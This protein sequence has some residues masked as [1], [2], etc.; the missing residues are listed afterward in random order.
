MSMGSPEEKN[1]VEDEEGEEGGRGPWRGSDCSL[2]TRREEDGGD[3]KAEAEVCC[4]RTNTDPFSDF[5]FR[6]IIGNIPRFRSS[7]PSGFW[8]FRN[9]NRRE[10]T[11]NNHSCVH[12]LSAR[13]L[14]RT[15][16]L[17]SLGLVLPRGAASTASAS[18]ASTA[19]ASAMAISSTAAA[20]AAT[21]CS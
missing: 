6:S 21:A 7:L 3:M 9:R 17:L 16:G 20:A 12:L 19:S 8:R 2:I 11:N 14:F 4:C 13:D 10:L 18:A 15:L 1:G 5:G